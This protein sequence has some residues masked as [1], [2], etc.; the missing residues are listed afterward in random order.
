[1]TTAV[2][3]NASFP[4]KK[5]SFWVPKNMLT[6]ILVTSNHTWNSKQIWIIAYGRLWLEI[7]QSDKQLL[8]RRLILTDC[9]PKFN[10]EKYVW[11]HFFLS[12]TNGLT[13][14]SF[15]LI[16]SRHYFTEVAN[17]FKFYWNYCRLSIWLHSFSRNKFKKEIKRTL[18]HSHFRKLWY[19]HLTNHS[20]GQ[21]FLKIL[22]NSNKFMVFHPLWA[23]LKPPPP[24]LTLLLFFFKMHPFPLPLP[25]PLQRFTNHGELHFGIIRTVKSWLRL[26]FDTLEQ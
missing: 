8:L 10:T 16:S 12:G 4:I 26:H 13:R 11:S 23:L 14:V 25:C 20:K 22:T 9:L 17:Y 3:S 7:K 15:F 6:Q 18:W 2:F 1:M 21:A 5:K 19:W 24:L